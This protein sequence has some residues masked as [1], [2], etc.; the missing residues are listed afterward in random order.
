MPGWRLRS[1]P[2]T[3]G[4]NQVADAGAGR[5]ICLGDVMVDVVAA[6]PGP[7]AL[8]SDVHAPIRYVPGGSAANT[9]AWLAIDGAEVTLIGRVGDD[10]AG[11]RAH[12]ELANAGI[13]DRLQID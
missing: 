12:V 9:A 8:G 13:V 5:I 11:T 2:P 4:P 7:L 1:R 3:P 10:A 6:L